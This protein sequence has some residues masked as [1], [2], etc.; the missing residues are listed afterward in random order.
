MRLLRA[1]DF[2]LSIIIADTFCLEKNPGV[3][4]AEWK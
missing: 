1:L 2:K 4:E 3:R